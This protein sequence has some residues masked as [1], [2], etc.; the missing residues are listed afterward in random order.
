MLLQKIVLVTGAAGF[1]GRYTAKC[2]HSHGW[3]VIGI[4]HGSWSESEWKYWGLDE[5]YVMNCDSS[6]L[7]AAR[8][9]RANVIVHT[10]GS[11]SVGLSVKQPKIDFFRNVS[12]TVEVLD[13]IRSRALK[14]K[15]V[16]LSSAAVYGMVTKL[17]IEETA[18]L[19][20]ISPYGLHK[21]IGEDLC[22]LYGKQYGLVSI[23]VRLF[24]VYGAGI[25][26]QLLWDAC[27]KL[28]G[29]EAVFWGTGEE[30][31]DW[32]H[33]ED[34]AELLFAAK[35]HATNSSPKVNGGCGSAVSINKLVHELGK[36]L[37]YQGNIQFN[38]KV[39]VGNPRDFLASVDVVNSWG[40][41]PKKNL[42]EGIREYVEWFKKRG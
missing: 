17:P 19:D 18:V 15:L 12:C 1:I 37:N 25:R 11:G 39:D 41:L 28:V 38:G 32:I 6:G 27:N 5:W 22:C 40:W 13:F 7:A 10:A 36:H 23:V 30:T 9:E 42:K 26:K 3:Y 35:D 34:V 21:K 24:S 4:G 20:P 29:D 14:T 2:F 33:V 31:R 8:G 16:Y